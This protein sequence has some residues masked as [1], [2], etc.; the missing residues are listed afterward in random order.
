MKQLSDNLFEMIM[1]ELGIC[2]PDAKHELRDCIVSQ[3]ETCQMLEICK[4]LV[5]ENLR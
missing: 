4:T 1:S 2:E 3:C 5:R